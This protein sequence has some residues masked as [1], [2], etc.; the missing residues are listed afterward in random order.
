MGEMGKHLS[1][2]QRAWDGK[3]S[4]KNIYLKYVFSNDAHLPLRNFDSLGSGISLQNT[5]TYYIVEEL[6][7]IYNICE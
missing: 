5:L 2:L 4:D 3:S 7:A 6:L 1:F